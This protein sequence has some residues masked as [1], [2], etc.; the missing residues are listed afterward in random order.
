[1][2]IFNSTET[3]VHCTISKLIHKDDLEVFA[4]FS[5]LIGTIRLHQV[6]SVFHIKPH[7]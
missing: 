4:Q 6:Q 1:M 5:M 3:I 2:E 7:L